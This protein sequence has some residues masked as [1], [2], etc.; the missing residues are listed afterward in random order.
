MRSIST[1]SARRLSRG[2]FIASVALAAAVPFIPGKSEPS[3][4]WITAFL[5]LPLLIYGWLGTLMASKHPDNPLGWLFCSIAAIAG[6]ATFALAYSSI[7]ST[8][9]GTGTAPLSDV[10]AWFLLLIPEPALAFILPVFLL[11]FPDGRLLSRRW[12]IAVAVAAMGSFLWIVGNLAI[13]DKLSSFAPPAWL[14][15]IPA[16]RGGLGAAAVLALTATL[17]GFASL[18]VRYRRS[19]GETKTQLR[20]LTLVLSAMVIASAIAI[21]A[22]VLNDNVGWVIAS[23][24][25]L[26][27]GFGILIGIPVAAAFA[28]LTFG[29]YDVG[30]VMRKQIAHRVLT[31]LLAI[32]MGFFGLITVAIL[33]DVLTPG[34]DQTPLSFGL[35]GLVVGLSIRPT[36]MLAARISQRLVYGGRATPYEVLTTFSGRLGETYATDDVLPRLATLLVEAVGADEAGVWLRLGGNLRLE[37]SWPSQ[38]VFE[39]QRMSAEALPETLPGNAFEVRDRG[40]LLG[41]ITVVMP[42]NDPM[43]K[44]KESLVRDLASQA[45]LVLR[46]VRLIEE[47]RSS[48]R[49]IVTAQDDRAKK[50]ERNIHDGAQQQLVAQAV[51]LRLTDALVERDPA[52]AREMLAQLQEDSHQTLEDLRDLARGIYPPLLADKGLGAALEAQA[53]R[54]AIPVVVQADDLGRFSQDVEAAVYF[55]CLEALQNI[56]KYAEASGARIELTAG[57]GSVRFLVTDDGR[58]FDPGATG[59]GTGL[60]GIADRLAALGGELDVAS[61][62]GSGTSLRGVVPS[63]VRAPAEGATP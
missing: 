13:S 55:S 47:L 11:L 30:F 27:D 8:E 60:Q 1:T 29:L 9:L 14:E 36:R 33:G 58:G 59:Y 25:A 63:G 53:R 6:T 19:T 37:A 50:L 38:S 23:L 44:T 61:A 18:L 22:Q 24:M 28:V 62:P 15:T 45:G 48:R 52:K 16:A 7:G 39:T 51:K 32:V 57:D 5:L 20:F 40:E 42:A 12:R 49:R 2:I 3:I 46:N 31:V 17:A 34:V 56:A 21:P 54:A 10:A 41:A 26:V 35:M 43:N 4:V